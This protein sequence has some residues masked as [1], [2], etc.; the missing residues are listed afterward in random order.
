MPLF[1]RGRAGGA[2]ERIDRSAGFLGLSWQRGWKCVLEKRMGGWAG[3]MCVS[4][5]QRKIFFFYFF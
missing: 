4:G 3:V 2:R 5:S 1:C